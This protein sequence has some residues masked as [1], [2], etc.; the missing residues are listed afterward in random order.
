MKFDISKYLKKY[1]LPVNKFLAKLSDDHIKTQKKFNKQAYQELLENCSDALI[2]QDLMETERK[3]K[4]KRPESKKDRPVSPF[5]FK[6]MW[7][8]DGKPLKTLES[9]M[10]YVYEK[11]QF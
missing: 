3:M 7:T 1:K 6:M 5:K 10:D 4:L 2:D 11:W 8:P 9:L